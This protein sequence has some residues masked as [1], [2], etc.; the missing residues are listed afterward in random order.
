MRQYLD[1]M[2]QVMQ[3]GTRKQDRTGV[4]TLSLF[5]HQM[6]FDLSQ[7]FPLITT[8]R[9]HLKSI[10][11]ELLWFLSGDTNVKYL[12]EKG[13]TIWDEWADAKGDLGPIYG[14]QWRSWPTPDGRKIDQIK[15]LIDGI[16]KNPK[17]RPQIV[18]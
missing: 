18:R 5:G 14:H 8:K 9:V 13:V 3:H 11:H 1:L 16:K 15:H 10:I 4:G 2:R 6:R 7:G 12:R 17:S